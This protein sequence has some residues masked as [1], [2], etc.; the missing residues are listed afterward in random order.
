MVES[1]KIMMPRVVKVEVLSHF[2]IEIT[3]RMVL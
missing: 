3:T 2:N 1:L